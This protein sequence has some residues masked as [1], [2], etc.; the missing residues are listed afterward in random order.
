M[1]LGIMKLTLPLL[2]IHNNWLFR[3][4]E[5]CITINLHHVLL[6]SSFVQSITRKNHYINYCV[7]NNKWLTLILWYL[8]KMHGLVFLKRYHDA[9]QTYHTM[10]VQLACLLL[11]KLSLSHLFFIWQSIQ[12]INFLFFFKLSLCTTS[13]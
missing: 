9:S 1:H 3:F 2:E 5:I 8:F 10:S 12:Y 11:C 7:L 13:K 6:I 4:L